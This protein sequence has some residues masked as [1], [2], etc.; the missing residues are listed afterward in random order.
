MQLQEICKKPGLESSRAGL[1]CEWAGRSFL[2][3]PTTGFRLWH[4][5]TCDLGIQIIASVNLAVLKLATPSGRAIDP[6][7]SH[8]LGVL[9]SY[10]LKRRMTGFAGVAQRTDR[11]KHK[12]KPYSGGTEANYAVAGDKNEVSV[13]GTYLNLFLEWGF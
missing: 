1:K 5:L 7:L 3:C 10:R 6:A 4:S 2:T 12:A 11:A 9:F 8:Q 13:V